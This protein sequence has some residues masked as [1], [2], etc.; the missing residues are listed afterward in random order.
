MLPSFATCHSMERSVIYERISVSRKHANP[1]AARSCGLSG[2]DDAFRRR[3][4]EVCARG[5]GSHAR[6]PANFPGRA[7]GYPGRRSEARR[8]L[9]SRYGCGHQA[10]PENARR[11]HAHSGR[12]QVPRSRHGF[13]PERSVSLWAHRGSAGERLQQDAAARRGAAAA[14]PLPFWTVHRSDCEE[15]AGRAAGGHGLAGPVLRCG[16]HRT[17]HQHF[18]FRQAEAAWAAASGAPSRAGGADAGA[19][20][21]YSAS[22]ERNLRKGA[23]ERQ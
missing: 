3:P 11:Q 16:F 8:P 21:G 20:V 2:Y 4:W 9:W 6:R 23:G 15:H 5:G 10:D 1:G 19:W 18:L 14:G 13:Y 22:G 7:E 17:E 12:R